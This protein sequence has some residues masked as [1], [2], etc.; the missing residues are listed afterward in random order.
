MIH[1]ANFTQL[2]E[3]GREQCGGGEEGTI[4]VVKR[5]AGASGGA[6]YEGGSVWEGREWGIGQG[7]QG[8]PVVG[9]AVDLILSVMQIP[10]RV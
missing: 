10:W 3:E 5:R 4:S 9:G 6:S 2:W 8:L 7:R 1:A